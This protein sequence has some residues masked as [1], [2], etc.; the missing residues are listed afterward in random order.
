MTGNNVYKVM[1]FFLLLFMLTGCKEKKPELDV[2]RKAYELETGTTESIE[3]KI[4]N[5]TKKL[6]V[7]FVSDNEGIASV[8]EDGLITA[9]RIGVAKI[10]VSI[11][12][13]PDIY[14]EISIKVLT[15]PLVLLG[16][17]FVYVGE[18]M[19]LYA[20]DRNN[21]ECVGWESLNPDIATVSSSGEVEGIAPGEAVIRI[22]SL[23][24]DHKVEK[25]ITVSF[26]EVESLELAVKGNP[27]VNV[28]SEITLE[29]TVYPG[30]ASPEITWYSD[31]D[32]IATVNGEGLVYCLRSG[33][34][35]I[36]ARTDNGIEG[37]ITLDITVDP[38]KILKSLNVE[39]PIVQYVTTYGITNKKE[40]VYG[41]VSRYFPGPLNLSVNIIK[42]TSDID[43]VPNPYIGEVATPEILNAA[44]F[45]T[46]RSGII[47][48]E[49]KNIVYHDTGNNNLGANAGMHA[50]YMI[51]PD[52]FYTYKARSWHYTVDD[53][54]VIQH[55]PD[56]EVAWQ[57]DTY[58]AYSTTIGIE[59]CVD[60]GSD[61]YTTWHR[62]AKLMADLLLKYNL[63]VGDVKQHYDFSQKNCPQTLRENDLY[64]NA[65]SLIEAEYLVLQELDGYTISFT[66]NAPEYVDNYGRIIKLDSAPK[67]I[68]YMVSIANDNGYSETIILYS[69]LPANIS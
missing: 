13:Y 66:S 65:V 22:Y 14:E 44:E 32:N 7:T 63:K 36:I 28:L 9:G 34:V 3:Y 53:K 42:T 6:N 4:K 29:C 35:D 58:Q 51:G 11:K 33:S 19:K 37:R 2:P 26:P 15:Y 61:L 68:G 40:L 67:R 43:G 16:N 24:T 12:E 69:T 41:S 17:G 27:A 50:S 38:I 23:I 21:P 52:N 18:T 60:E 49:I 10:I 59:T 30:N 20:S 39:N 1:F 62:A 57:G 5:T 8:N 56:D 55:L 46:V 45:K 48:P 64:P 25:R 54:G 47:K 31:N